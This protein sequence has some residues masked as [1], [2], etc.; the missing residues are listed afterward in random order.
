MLRQRG[1]TLGQAQTEQ[2]V[3]GLRGFSRPWYELTW[4]N[5]GG[6]GE[7]TW[8]T[9]WQALPLMTGGLEMLVFGCVIGQALIQTFWFSFTCEGLNDRKHALFSFNFQ[10]IQYRWLYITCVSKQ[11]F[12]FIPTRKPFPH[13]T[14]DNSSWKYGFLEGNRWMKGGT[15]VALTWLQCL[16]NA[17]LY[18][19]LL[20]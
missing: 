6:W 13:L 15:E 7:R 3:G 14:A 18:P 9:I 2:G 12:T 4:C 8:V 10:F 11:Q 1:F 5:T 19:R 16:Y 17:F 20:F